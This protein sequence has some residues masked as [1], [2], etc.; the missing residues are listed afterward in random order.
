MLARRSRKLQE[1]DAYWRL[2]PSRLSKLAR[3]FSHVQLCE[4]LRNNANFAR[5]G[6]KDR[7][8]EIPF[9]PN[10]QVYILTCIIPGSTRPGLGSGTRRRDRRPHGGRPGDIGG[11]PGPRLDQ[12]PATRSRRR[13][14][15]GSSRG[16]AP[17]R[18]R[19][20]FFADH[21]LR[22]GFAARGFDDAEL[23]ALAVL[24]PSATRL[25][26]ERSSPRRRFPPRS[27]S[28][29]TR[30]MSRPAWSPPSCRRGPDKAVDPRI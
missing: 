29:I 22:R 14:R 20:G 15:T 21:E 25:D 11:D 10:K 28:R 17:H 6:A 26:V 12:L 13:M 8:S 1:S 7:V 18:L 27:R 16:D 19:V 24:D 4:L 9:I 2:C 3:G 5:T 23:A 30:T